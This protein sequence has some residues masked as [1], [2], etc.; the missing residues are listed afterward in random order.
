MLKNIKI[1]YQCPRCRGK[2]IQNYNLYIKCMECNLE[3]DKRDIRR[4]DEE[5]V[6]ALSEKFGILRVL[7]EQYNEK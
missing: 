1:E 5:D 7:S 4:F 2:Q 6:L 3:F